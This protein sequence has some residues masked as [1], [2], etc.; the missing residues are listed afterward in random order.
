MREAERAII[1]LAGLRYFRTQITR[2]TAA[3]ASLEVPFAATAF[4]FRKSRTASGETITACD[5]GATVAGPAIIAGFNSVTPANL[6]SPSTA[7]PPENPTAGG[8]D[9][10]ASPPPTDANAALTLD[11]ARSEERRVGKEC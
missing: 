4:A 7:G 11:T 10:A 8:G 1:A 3:F 9:S 5:A 6:P 2:T